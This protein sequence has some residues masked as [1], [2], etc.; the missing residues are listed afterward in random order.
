M[1]RVVHHQLRDVRW[2]LQG[3]G[4]RQPPEL[5]QDVVGEAQ[6]QSLC[7]REKYYGRVATSPS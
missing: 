4:N 2:V 5:L 1:R 7:W 6:G 3:D